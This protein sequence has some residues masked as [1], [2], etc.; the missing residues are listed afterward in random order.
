MAKTKYDIWFCNCGRI[1]FMPKSDWDW[2]AED[3]EHR[4]VLQVCRNCGALYE[5]FLT[6]SFYKTPGFD[7]NGYD[8]I[9]EDR[10][11]FNPTD[12]IQRRTYLDRGIKVPLI[13][14]GYADGHWSNIY[15]NAEYMRRMGYP[16]DIS[17]SCEHPDCITVNTDRL[18]REVQSKYPEEADELLK[19]ISGYLA[20]INWKG[21]KYE[22]A[23]RYQLE[24]N[25]M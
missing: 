5:H 20:G 17:S 12:D 9:N 25:K 11:I 18:I 23:Y 6:E 13:E 3:C 4:R 15:F 1:H 8:Y 10:I 19:C 7:L 22:R 14:G 2:M 16:S 21:T 24:K